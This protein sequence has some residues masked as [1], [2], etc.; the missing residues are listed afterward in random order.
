MKKNRWF[1]VVLVAAFLILAFVIFLHRDSFFS[2]E[3]M[4]TRERSEAVSVVSEEDTTYE[5]SS[6]RKKIMPPSAKEKVPELSGVEKG[7]QDQLQ[8][9]VEQF[10]DYLD[11]QNYIK[12]YKLEE[13]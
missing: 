6:V 5:E 3:R 2:D 9:R 11:R 10:F 4:A 13:G 8:E 1:A 7:D 12:A